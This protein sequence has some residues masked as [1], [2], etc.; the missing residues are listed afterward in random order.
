MEIKMNKSKNLIKK[1]LYFAVGFNVIILITYFA[2]TI[3]FYNSTNG[4]VAVMALGICALVEEIAALVISIGLWDQS[5]HKVSV[6]DIVQTT[7]FGVFVAILL[8]ISRNGSISDQL[9]L[10]TFVVLC[11]I[12]FQT[13][14][15]QTAVRYFT[16]QKDP[17]ISIIALVALYLM[18]GYTVF[19]IF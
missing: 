3:G 19:F 12:M 13:S 7:S 5:I 2:I 4:A 11:I 6:V 14:L 1:L 8:L 16:K 10:D 17:L 18:M 15:L 9:H